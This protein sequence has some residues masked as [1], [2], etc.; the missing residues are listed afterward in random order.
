MIDL[1]E[2]LRE[3]EEEDDREQKDNV[4]YQENLF[5]EYVLRKKDRIDERQKLEKRFAAG[6]LVTGEKGLRKE[7]AAFDLAYFG[8]AYLPHYFTRKSPA[9][10]E[11]LDELWSSGVMKGKNPFRD[12]KEIARLDGSQQAIAAPRG[13]A[14]T[15]NFTFKDTLHAVLYQ[16]KHYPILLSDSSEQA[17]GFLDDI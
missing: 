2:Y 13:H 15:T 14:K 6:E 5:A 9:F 4:A 7:L 3:L 17:E 12:A 1:E 16:Y 10:H 8:R 11:E